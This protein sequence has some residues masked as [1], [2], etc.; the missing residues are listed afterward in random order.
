ME[1]FTNIEPDGG[2]ANAALGAHDAAPSGHEAEF[3]VK[4]L[5]HPDHEPK[6]VHAKDDATMLE[7]IDKAAHKLDVKLLPNAHTPLDQLR[8]VYEDHRVGEPL[9]LNETVEEFLRHV[10]VVRKTFVLRHYD[11][12]TGRFKVVDDPDYEYTD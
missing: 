1:G 3:H 6:H 4:V 11:T 5:H 9:N 2:K 10:G 8:G 12:V 7:V